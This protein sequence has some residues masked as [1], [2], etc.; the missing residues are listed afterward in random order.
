MG[1]SEWPARQSESDVRG[2]LGDEGRGQGGL[3]DTPLSLSG[4][5]DVVT[6]PRSGD[7]L[8]RGGPA[9]AGA[10]QL[11]KAERALK[12]MVDPAREG[13][14]NG[15]GALARSSQESDAEIVAAYEW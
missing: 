11:M 2:A 15:A 4:G 7:P 8:T 6:G 12:R 3:Q 5:G 14:G 10:L 1:Q 13:P 9:R